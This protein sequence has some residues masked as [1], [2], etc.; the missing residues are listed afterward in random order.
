MLHFAKILELQGVYATVCS[1]EDLSWDE[2]A[3]LVDTSG[4]PINFVYNRLVDFRFTQAK[5]AHLREA[6][7]SG[8]VTV[9]PHPATYARVADKRLLLKLVSPVVPESHELSTRPIEEWAAE[10]KKWVF[11]PP[12]GA[13]S[14][15]VYRGDKISKKTLRQLPE[16]TIAQQMC[17]PSNS[18]NGTKYDL[19]V[20]TREAQILGVVTRHFTGQVFDIFNMVVEQPMI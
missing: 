5:H 6:A 18:S 11:K 7:L 1:P 15:G 12:D 9:S 13:G 19:R 2:S 8:S 3:G 16:T 4:H 10:K 17:P 20:Y 14:K